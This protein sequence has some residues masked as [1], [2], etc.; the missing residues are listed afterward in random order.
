MFSVW[1]MFD[2]DVYP[3]PQWFAEGRPSSPF[4][5]QSPWYNQ[6]VTYSK[7]KCM[8][9]KNKTQQV[10][11]SNDHSYASAEGLDGNTENIIARCARSTPRWLWI[12]TGCIK[13]CFF[14]FRDHFR[15]GCEPK[16]IA[17]I[18][19]FPWSFPFTGFGCIS[20]YNFDR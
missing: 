13:L 3:K 5:S 2:K 19:S 7:C 9:I 8:I 1:V 10:S 15:Q 14:F 12:D 4:W 16:F 20:F 11:C 18:L 6:I 17:T